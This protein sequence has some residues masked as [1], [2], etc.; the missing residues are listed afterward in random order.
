MTRIVNMEFTSWTHQRL[1]K[2]QHKTAQELHRVFHKVRQ[3][4][5]V[6]Q[7]Q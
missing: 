3:E 1:R 2:V 6:S 7:T 5:T 4:G